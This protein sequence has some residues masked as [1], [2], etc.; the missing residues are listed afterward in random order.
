MN[1][2]QLR[3]EINQAL[4][5]QIDSYC[6][7]IS[8][9]DEQLV[10]IADSLKTFLTDGKRFR[11]IFALLGFMGTGK[12]LNPKIYEAAAAL[13]FLQASA[14]IHDD[15]MD[16]SATRRGKPAMHKQFGDAAAILIGDLALVWN[17]QALHNSQ[18][19]TPEV[20]RIHD[21]MRT[22]LMAG[23]FLDVY[24]QT[25][26]SYSVER[27]LKIARYKSGKYSIERPLHYGA[28]LANPE[29]KE[30]FYQ[31]YSEYGLPLGE[32]FQLRDDLL[33]VYGDPSQTGKPAG[34]DLREGKRTA[35]V[36]FAYD[37]GNESIKR[38]INEKLGTSD[39]EGL[40]E[41][42]T[43][44][45]APIHVEDLIE[46]LAESALDAI[47]RDELDSNAKKLLNEMVALVTKRNR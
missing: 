38:L 15:L 46:K 9:I 40:A 5:R 6:A 25:Q 21:I 36:A 27:S 7:S 2:D 11:S 24:E 4:T 44:S 13:E 3:Q 1:I 18:V 26:Q 45:G 32:A 43:E 19:T 31:I 10:P 12:N 29:N 23:Q 17:E 42:I 8:E 35:L 39:I 20:N 34:D 47:E 37:R 28:A 14:L 41:A 30:T 16:G 33:G 22:E